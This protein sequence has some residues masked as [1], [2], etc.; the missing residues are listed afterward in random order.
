[1]RGG[2]STGLPTKTE[3]ADLMMALYGRNSDNPMIILAPQTPSDCFYMA[4]EAVRLAWEHMTP[5]MLL[6]DGHLGNGSEPWKFPKMKEMQDIKPMEAKLNGQQYQPYFRDPETLSRFMAI[7]GTP[8]MEHR[9]GG[10]EKEDVTGNVS[11]DPENHEKMYH[12]RHE[13]VKKVADYI[14]EQEIFGDKE[15]DLL[16]VGWGSTYGSIAVSI[17]ELEMDSAKVGHLHLR[18][19][20][21]LP[22][23]LEEL[24]Q[25]FKRILVCELNL[26]Q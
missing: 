15:G 1:Q 20:Y 12:L 17:D 26:G 19:L 13:K 16:V 24:F 10:L 21:P 8:G 5:V 2:P 7:P 18:Y 9:I 4:Y 11:Y 25:K 3:Q 6:S 14:P 22:K 23:N